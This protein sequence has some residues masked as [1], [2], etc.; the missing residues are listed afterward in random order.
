MKTQVLERP[1][2]STLTD[3]YVHRTDPRVEELFPY[4]PQ[5]ERDWVRRAEYLDSRTS[6]R[7]DSIPLAA[8]LEKYNRRS[9]ASMQTMEAINHLADGALVIVGGQQAGLW[10]GPLMILHKAITVISA[11]RDAE[12]RLGRS[13][14]PVFWIA[15][16]DHDWEE[17]CHTYLPGDGGLQKLAMARPAGPRT[18]VSR[19]II[20]RAVWVEQLSA[21]AALLPD[22]LHKP[23]LIRKLE[24]LSERSSTLSEQLAAVLSWLFADEGLVLLDADD[25]ELRQLESPML[26]RM[27]RDN[28]QLEE[29]F[30]TVSAEVVAWGY[31]LQAEAE[32]NS[33]N[34]FYYRKDDRASGA[35]ERTKLYRTEHGFADRRGLIRLSLAE[36]TVAAATEPEQFSNNVLSRPMMQDY[37]LPVLAVVLGPGEIGYWGITGR[38]FQVMGMQ[39]PIVVPRMSFTLIDE[40]TAK[41]MEKY[42]LT[43]Q[44]VMFRFHEFRDAWLGAQDEDKLGDKFEVME[45]QILK[46]YDPLLMDVADRM[47]G[48]AGLTAKNRE[49]LSTHIA[50]MRR[51]VEDELERRHGVSL[52]QL[53]RI[54]LMLY[55]EGIPQERV[56]NFTLYWNKYGGEWLQQL[57][58]IPF[59]P[60]GKHRLLYL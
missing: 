18:S 23:G 52:K 29:S 42:A 25:P 33:A 2:G 8:V 5:D 41:H 51:R 43:M 55:P 46:L 48:L 11:A 9:G 3:A 54:R 26:Q 7:V 57:L 15:G 45:Q 10:G 47:P 49:L 34:L 40:T 12:R 19:T 16:E 6:E 53:E 32:P 38:A 31:T 21:L 50:F 4:H 22:T 27:L 20:D 28:D 13:V 30:R 39:M 56:L 36:A 37:V 1:P 24:T 17:A 59:D 44:D 35:G 14:V 60:T 58:Q